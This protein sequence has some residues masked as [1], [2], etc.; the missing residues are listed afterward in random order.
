MR[1]A[2]ALVF[3]E[4]TITNALASAS[5]DRWHTRR[6]MEVPAVGLHGVHDHLGDPGTVGERDR[7]REPADARGRELAEI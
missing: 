6:T 1:R 3:T 7:S 5:E 4:A 2:K